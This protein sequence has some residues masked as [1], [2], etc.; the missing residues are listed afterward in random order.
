MMNLE[1]IIAKCEANAIPD[2]QIDCSEIPPLTDEQLAQMKP[3]H[4]V[5]RNIWKPVKKTV[6]MRIDADILESLKKNGKG[7]QTKVNA[8]LRQAVASGQI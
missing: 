5:N 3:C 4:L 6:T 1:E 7:W 8:L 2:D